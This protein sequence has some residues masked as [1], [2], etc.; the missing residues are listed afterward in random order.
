M[1]SPE[2]QHVVRVVQALLDRPQSTIEL[3]AGEFHQYDD[4][5]AARAIGDTL[6]AL[7]TDGAI[8]GPDAAGRYRLCTER[9]DVQ[10][11][12]AAI[13]RYQEGRR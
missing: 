5:A 6:A 9:L 8:A 10:E 4:A 3:R 12:V 13:K 2:P 11:L 1:I 7:E